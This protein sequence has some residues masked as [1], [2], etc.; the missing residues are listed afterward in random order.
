MNKFY[1]PSNQNRAR[2]TEKK[3]FQNIFEIDMKITRQNNCSTPTPTALELPLLNFCENCKKK[4]N[5]LAY[6]NKN[7]LRSQFFLTEVA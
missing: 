1:I 2:S 6:V 7:S 4:L 3:T 5:R